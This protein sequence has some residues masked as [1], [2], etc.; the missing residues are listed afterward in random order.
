MRF[1]ILGGL[2]A[3]FFDAVTPVQRKWTTERLPNGQ[4]FALLWV[5][6]FGSAT[7][8]YHKALISSLDS[9]DSEFHSSVWL[10]TCVNTGS[11]DV[12]S[13]QIVFS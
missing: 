5:T 3:G 1:I 4:P 12:G 9:L 2:I 6:M 11:Y 7:S 8:V 13:T 10:I